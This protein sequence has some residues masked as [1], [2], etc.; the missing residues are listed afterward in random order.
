MVIQNMP[1]A[2]EAHNTAIDF[3]LIEAFFFAYRDFT[4][5]ADA[6]LET[7]D[8]GRAHH[9]V[10]HFVNRKSGLTVAELLDILKITKQSLARVLKQLIDSG[11]I[12]QVTGPKDKRQRELYPT[13]K[14]RELALKL[15]LPQSCRINKALQQSGSGARGQV[16]AF[17]TAMVG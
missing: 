15:A 17:L 1:P 13:E 11:H 5:D 3:G 6:I 9:R 8:F 4:A 7:Y 12:S 14:G 16:E 2:A 10:L